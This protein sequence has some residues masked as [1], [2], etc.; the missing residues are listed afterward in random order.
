MDC[1]YSSRRCPLGKKAIE[2]RKCLKTAVIILFWNYLPERTLEAI[3]IQ[4]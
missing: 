2:E 4:Y 1:Q 3:E